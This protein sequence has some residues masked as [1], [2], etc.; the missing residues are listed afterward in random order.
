MIGG[1]GGGGRGGGG[2]GGGGRRPGGG[3]RG[4]G[5]YYNSGP[6][7]GPASLINI[8]IPVAILFALLK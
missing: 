3:G 2:R 7:H 8:I 5:G 6:T 4:G 1:R